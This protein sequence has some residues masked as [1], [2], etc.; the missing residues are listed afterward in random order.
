MKLEC[1]QPLC[2]EACSSHLLPLSFCFSSLLSLLTT[3]LPATRIHEKAVFLMGWEWGLAVWV[4]I[5]TSVNRG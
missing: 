2:L 4:A 5:L 3:E 1:D